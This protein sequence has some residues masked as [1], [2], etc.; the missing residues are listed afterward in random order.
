M[1]ILLDT[2]AVSIIV[3]ITKLDGTA[4]TGLLFSDV[5]AGIKKA[6]A[7]VFSVF[8]L[9]ALNFTDVGGGYYKIDLTSADTNSI[10]LL[11]FRFSAVDAAPSLVTYNVAAAVTPVVPPTPPDVPVTNII[12]G[13]IFDITGAL[14]EDAS[15]TARVLSSPMILHPGAAGIGVGG[16]IIFTRTD[17]AGMF[18]LTLVANA[19]VEISI[20]AIGYKRTI[21]VPAGQSTNLFDIP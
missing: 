21:T 16:D 15:V 19:S 2:T 12:Y 13:Y 20:P 4:F 10:G 3:P 9:T 6:N 7:S 1:A 11:Y 14:I 17:S 8:T 5:T 18:E